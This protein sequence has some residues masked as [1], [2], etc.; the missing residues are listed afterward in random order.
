MADIF[1]K[2]EQTS[3]TP[4][5]S[6]EYV[7]TENSSSSRSDS[8][9]S[10]A[11]LLETNSIITEKLILP[12]DFSNEAIFNEFFIP[13]IWDTLPSSAKQYLR[14]FLPEPDYRSTSSQ[15]VNDLLLHRLERFGLDQMKSLQINLAKG[16]FR[17]DIA[18]LRQ[19]LSKSLNKEQKML[20]LQRYLRLARNVLL[21]REVTLMNE[22]HNQSYPKVSFCSRNRPDTRFLHTSKQEKF[23]KAA[24]KR[25][26]G[27]IVGISETIGVPLSL[28]DEEE[29][30]EI[31]AAA[32]VRKNRKM[33]SS[34]S[35][36]TSMGSLG[37]NNLNK[38][39]STYGGITSSVSFNSL[40][41]SSFS[42][43][44]LFSITD[45][46]YHR[47]LM[48]HRKRKITEPDNPEMVLEGL[49]L[50]DVV[51]RT[52]I[53]AGY[54]R[55]L[56]F[57]KHNGLAEIKREFDDIVGR[58][59]PK[60]QKPLKIVQNSEVGKY[61][62]DGNIGKKL[63]RI[64]NADNKF[65]E[66]VS[67]GHENE[68]CEAVCLE[69]PKYS[70]ELLGQ[71]KSETDS[72]PND[73]D[74]SVS[75]TQT[76]N[77][78]LYTN[79]KHSC[80]F[81]LIRDLF[82]SSHD[83]R[84]TLD[85][86]LQKLSDWYNSV[87]IPRRG[88]YALCTTITEW[89]AML[90][91][92][93]R[94][95]A[96]D[97]HTKLRDF[98][99]YI[100]RKTTM[101]VLQWIGASRDGDARLEPLCEFW[102]NLKQQLENE[103]LTDTDFT[104]PSSLTMI[105]AP[106]TRQT[107][108]GNNQSNEVNAF[109]CNE[110]CTTD[111]DSMIAH[112]SLA[113]SSG[114]SALLSMELDGM[115][116]EED[117]GSTSE[118]SETPPPPRY[119]TDW[120]VR[121]ATDEEIHSFRLQERQRYENPHMAYT[122]REHSYNS[123]VGPVKGIYTQVPGM[124]KAR[125]H[126]ML[127]A[128]RPNFVTILTLVRD[129]AARL[130]NGEGTRADI[131][132]LLKSS[133]YISP[134]A[135]EQILQTIVSGAL[136]RMHTEHDPCV[137]YDTKRKIWIYLHRNRT[138]EE[139]EK[140]HHQ[141]QGIT[142]HKK[143]TAKRLLKN[144]REVVIPRPKASD[145]SIGGLTSGLVSNEFSSTNFMVAQNFPHSDDKIDATDAAMSVSTG[146]ASS[147]LINHPTSLLKRQHKNSSSTTTLSICKQ[148]V[149]SNEHVD[150]NQ[151]MDKAYSSIIN[152]KQHQTEH[153]TCS[154]DHDPITTTPNENTTNPMATTDI[155]EPKF[156][157]SQNNVPVSTYLPTGKL[158]PAMTLASRTPNS[159]TVQSSLI[160]YALHTKPFS[161][162]MASTKC[163]DQGSSTP[164][165]SVRQAQSSPTCSGSLR[166]P[167]LSLVTNGQ[168][169][170]TIVSQSFATQS[171]P[172]HLQ[173]SMSVSATSS[174][175]S[176]V[177]N[178]NDD[179]NVDKAIY[180]IPSGAVVN[181]STPAVQ[182][183]MIISRKFIMNPAPA[184]TALGS[185]SINRN[186]VGLDQSEEIRQDKGTNTIAISKPTAHVFKTAA[187][188]INTISLGNGQQ[189][190]LSTAQQKHIL[191]NL[192]S[193]QQKQ[194]IVNWKG[195]YKTDVSHTISSNNTSDTAGT[196][197]DDEIKSV[198]G[199]PQP[200]S[201]SNATGNN[202]SSFK[203]QQMQKLQRTNSQ[204]LKFVSPQIVK[205]T[206]RNIDAL[207]KIRASSIT[208][209]KTAGE[210]NSHTVEKSSFASPNYLSTPTVKVTKL[211][212]STLLAA[213]NT[214]IITKQAEQANSNGMASTA[215]G[216]IVPV[217]SIMP[218]ATVRV[219]KTGTGTTNLMKSNSVAAATINQ[220]NNPVVARHVTSTYL[221]NSFTQIP[222]ESAISGGS[223]DQ[224]SNVV[225]KQC[226]L[227][228]LNVDS[229]RVTVPKSSSSNL[230]HS[231]HLKM[232]N[233]Q[234]S[235]INKDAV[236][237][238]ERAS[239][240][241]VDSGVQQY[242]IFSQSNVR[243]VIPVKPKATSNTQLES[244]GSNV[245]GK[246]N[247]CTSVNFVCETEYAPN[248]PIATT[249]GILSSLPTIDNF[250]TT[251]PAKLTQSTKIK[252]I[253]TKPLC[254]NV[255]MAQQ[256]QQSHL[257]RTITASKQ[258]ISGLV[259]GVINAK[260][261]GVRNVATSKSYCGSSLS[262]INS[263]GTN[264]E[265]IGGTPGTNNK[266]VSDTNYNKS[267]QGSFLLSANVNCKI[268]TDHEVKDHTSLSI[269][270]HDARTITTTAGT[271]QMV[272][273]RSHQNNFPK[274]NDC[275]EDVSPVT[276]EVPASVPLPTVT[277]VTSG[278]GATTLSKSIVKIRPSTL[279][280]SG[281]TTKV[282]DA[283]STKTLVQSQRVILATSSGELFTQPI[284]LAPGY[285]TTGPINIKRL[286]VIPGTK[287]NKNSTT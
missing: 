153:V 235:P 95:L 112:N 69:S 287:Q 104:S 262:A 246:L 178:L 55:I 181:Q 256:Q 50:K 103:N 18:K 149:S 123:V 244:S 265:S 101:N 174:S 5:A 274:P 224:L 214:K 75:K 180:T 171:K 88:W 145:A 150:P 98:V 57:P 77:P 161:Y 128:D 191:Q 65:T 29:C 79:S 215:V 239:P 38:R 206:P 243:G 179:N 158:S 89:Q 40:D 270:K 266:G 168:S 190:I 195:F 189:S 236:C 43:S 255:S 147:Y 8:E 118:R 1:V 198:G 286:K 22:V 52:Q 138:E 115:L 237:T 27:E 127:V 63:M 106:V 151:P 177:I 209:P 201:Q 211:N 48:Q 32:P 169:T 245:E 283:S 164:V 83:H 116:Q 251:S 67:K 218:T 41:S 82:C 33:Y 258:S 131:C 229:C 152:S 281:S 159:S 253:S 278:A 160:S 96:G 64:E 162:S 102:H 84:L 155:M 212:S 216:A 269:V 280:D 13:S 80:F 199:A 275:A 141:Y 240:G 217:S 120:T 232:T 94:F 110:K 197:N 47:L 35:N 247:Q 272:F 66:R 23:R 125:G 228:P 202:S 148:H 39:C 3:A 93:V 144:D 264:I 30:Y 259:N 86:I 78:A 28:S 92:A 24:K 173:L 21:S 170:P 111:C 37:T 175:K 146:G 277:T 34:T 271:C 203:H 109:K 107:K 227:T 184:G 182:P 16:N 261:V 135:T 6:D 132:E 4:L 156:V 121:K 185:D 279:R 60:T 15:V 282:L 61:A 20:D 133:Q 172:L 260:I 76:Q 59:T 157:N 276:P 222:K 10:N 192:L 105:T 230:G 163:I 56:P 136:D 87:T 14:T 122:Y 90:Q 220:S 167:S 26:L 238:S 194:S 70:L 97:F 81:S 154:K 193:Q 91:S 36:E 54:R 12:K 100:E 31:C 42:A 142:K 62:N 45:T 248:K 74:L 44:K 2:E 58:E 241:T 268:K 114:E 85:E 143:T 234:P 113:N 205:I 249:D 242:A 9:E 187:G 134:S 46:H 257:G 68:R 166:Q 207:N 210:S 226:I 108:D 73:P 129:A 72:Y 267:N 285:Q 254:S 204:I 124:S 250:N 284:I 183:S 137:K 126:N 223:L 213:A 231:A 200:I 71:S 188:P 196:N 19:T 252:V 119:P 53:A 7:D 11:S 49:K 176:G 130:P 219:L 273:H 17:A 208:I 263:P 225:R 140:L 99:P 221:K 165:V 233:N 186:N 117:D 25:Y 51:T 139:F